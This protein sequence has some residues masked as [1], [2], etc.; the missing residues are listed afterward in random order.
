MIHKPCGN[1]MQP[2]TSMRNPKSSEFYCHQCHASI[3][4]DEDTARRM[5]T[6][7]A[8]MM[9]AAKRGRGEGT[10]RRSA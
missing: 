5:I 8:A 10:E 1:E 6:H 3:L 9:E 4:M 7:Q 2:I